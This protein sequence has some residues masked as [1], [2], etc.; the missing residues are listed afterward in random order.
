MSEYNAEDI[1]VLKGLEGVRKR[2]AMYIGSTDEAGINQLLYEVVDNCID[3]AMAG[4]CKNID[5]TINSDRSA[6]ITDDGRGIPVDIHPIEK[7]SA[8]TVV[9]TT[10][11]SGGKFDNNTY[12]VSGGLHGVGVSVVNALSKR[13]ELIVNRDGFAYYQDYSKGIALN[14]LIKT[15]KTDKRGTSITF[16]PDDEDIFST[17]DFNSVKIAKRLRELAF[18]NPI[19]K[20]RFTDEINNEKFE[21]HYK[22]GVSE[23]VKYLNN[24][25][26]VIFDEPVKIHFYDDVNKIDVDLA[27]QYTTGYRENI[28]SFANAIDTA[29]GGLHLASFKAVLTKAI[30]QY[31]LENG[32]LKKD[33]TFS[34]DDTREGL[35]A[36]VSVKLPDPQFEGQTKT[37]LV[38]SEIKG[39]IFGNLLGYI[40][41]YLLE[42]PDISKII[43]DK[44]ITANRSRQA[45][46]RAREL[47]RRKTIFDVGTLPGKLADCASRDPSI[48]ELFLVEGDSAG[49]SAK[50]ARD[51]NFQAILPLKGKILNVEKSRLDKMLASEEIK[52][53]ITA[54]GCGV[55]E[56]FDIKKA[57]YHKIILMTDADVDGSHI[58][59][60]LLT[61]FFRYMRD[62]IDN[63]Y[64]YIAKP[65]LFK[66]KR[67]G[68]EL[69]LDD[70]KDLEFYLLNQG[71]RNMKLEVGGKLFESKELKIL[72]KAY[73]NY[74]RFFGLLKEKIGSV[75][76][77]ELIIQ[78]IDDCCDVKTNLDALNDYLKQ[79]FPD[80]KIVEIKESD[81]GTDVIYNESGF[82]QKVRID[83]DLI[84]GFDFVAIKKLIKNDIFKPPFTL[85]NDKKAAY[86]SVVELIETIEEAARKGIQIQR[87]KGLGE[88][89]PEQLWETT[90]NP[91]TRTIIKV[92]VDDEIE[93]DRTFSVL[94]GEDVAPRRKFIEDYA[95][96]AENIDV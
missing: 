69:Y 72:L 55:G 27:F 57:R 64:L 96:K 24:G 3:E 29:E 48:S 87:Y 34:G 70:E 88:M 30:N 95:Q 19:V 74:K 62:L 10:L 8:A 78:K 86:S 42:H 46:K 89:N 75:A 39:I 26:S 60:L 18:L 58:Q 15:G 13:L 73:Y 23:F 25:K 44:C 2:P 63:G 1:K 68:K 49:G 53:I 11:H 20:I 83:N 17:S 41:D 71:I 47:V 91:E 28:Y 35:T 82:N 77:T 31:A 81:S 33:M 36:V 56:G 9:L 12:K 21:F 76:I 7:I 37:K 22:G 93:C 59:T 84:E 54:V 40:K 50:Q 6:T 45:A 65:P 61:L 79:F 5:V 66:L 32:M 80:T 52:H 38:N 4:F 14:P 51:K 16:I 92:E 67:K 43:V 85:I 90:M 94:M